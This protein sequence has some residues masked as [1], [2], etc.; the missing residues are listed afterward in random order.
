MNTSK[1]EAATPLGSGVGTPTLNVKFGSV[2][3]GQYLYIKQTGAAED[4]V[5]WSVHDLNVACN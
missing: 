3:V 4:I 5:C 1:D 2:V